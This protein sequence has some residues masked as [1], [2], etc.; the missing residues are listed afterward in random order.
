MRPIA[1]LAAETPADRVIG[2]LREHRTHQAVVIDG[3]DR[4]LGV[5]TIQD[6]LAALLGSGDRPR[7]AR[8]A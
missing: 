7:D 3:Q 4:A 8:P 5:I 1:H 2:V 6:V